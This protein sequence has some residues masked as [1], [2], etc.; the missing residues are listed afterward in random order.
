MF[1]LPPPYRFPFA[2]AVLLHVLVLLTLLIKIPRSETFRMNEVNNQTS[3][4]NAVAINSEQ[5][6]D[7]IAEIKQAEKQKQAQRLAELK[8]LEEAAEAAK[9][10]RMEEQQHL[11]ELKAEQVRLAKE[12]ID[13]EK[14]LA[15]QKTVALKKQ[16]E[17]LASALAVKQQKLQQQLMQQQM[18]QEQTQLAKAQ[19][20]QMQ[21]GMLDQYK[22]KIIQAIQQQWIVPEDADNKKLSCLLIIELAPSG[23]VLKVETAR[24]SGDPVLDRSARVAVF[25]ASPLPVPKDPALFSAFRELRL[26][27]R[28]E[29]VSE[30]SLSN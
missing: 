29:S 22:A 17:Q 26:T 7:Q 19:T 14:A 30:Q 16:Q 27:V 4:I 6:N 15:K 23:V 1:K 13:Q 24:T 18:Q 5:V 2:I 25:K 21:Q 28:P 8:K 12:R 11:A 10:K 9:Q 3:V 20:Q